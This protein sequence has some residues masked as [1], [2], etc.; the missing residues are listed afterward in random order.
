MDFKSQ[1]QGLGMAHTDGLVD[2]LCMDLEPLIV[3]QDRVYL[4][5]PEPASRGLRLEL[6]KVQV[7]PPTI[8]NK[9]SAQETTKCFIL[10]TAKDRNEI[11]ADCSVLEHL[12]GRRDQNKYVSRKALKL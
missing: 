9:N 7:C 12:N 1:E 10:P 11:N 8:T 2:G 4:I 6:L 3:R 5:R